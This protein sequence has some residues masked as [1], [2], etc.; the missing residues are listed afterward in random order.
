VLIG[1]PAQVRHARSIRAH[2]RTLV[3]DPNILPNVPLAS[4]WIDHRNAAS[5]QDLWD[6]ASDTSGQL[7]YSPFVSHYPRWGRAEAT[8]VLCLLDRHKIVDVETDGIG[9]PAQVL[10]VAVIDQDGVPLFAT[11]VRPVAM[12]RLDGIDD[13][14]ARDSRSIHGS[15]AQMLANAPTLS[16]G[17]PRLVEVL[18]EPETRSLT[19]NTA[20]FDLRII[21]TAAARE[22]LQVPVL[23]GLCLMKLRTAYYEHD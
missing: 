11:L 9:K 6:A 10:E 19:A 7:R 21:R 14:E 20:D 8:A 1:T 23:H 12:T 5:L 18:T 15:T 4:F 3:G 16:E 2:F 17:W 13:R 22:G